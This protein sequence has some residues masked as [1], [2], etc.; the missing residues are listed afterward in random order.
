[1]YIIQQCNPKHCVSD[2]RLLTRYLSSRLH[3]DHN[4]CTAMGVI[5][6]MP[7]SEAQVVDSCFEEDAYESGISLLNHMRTEG[8]KPRP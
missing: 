6:D 8:T 3:V 5:R 1:M 2:N 4:Q 7:L